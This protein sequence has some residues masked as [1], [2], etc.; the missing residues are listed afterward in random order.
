LSKV[1]TFIGTVINT[2]RLID[3]D[4]RVSNDADD[5]QPDAANWNG[6]EKY[7]LPRAGSKQ[8]AAL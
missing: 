7:A 3:G 2:S 8:A 6:S 4:E 5:G 1:I